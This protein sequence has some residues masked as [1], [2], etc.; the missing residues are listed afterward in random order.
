[1]FEQTT[2]GTLFEQQS[3]PGGDPAVAV[4]DARSIIVMANDAFCILLNRMQHHVLGQPLGGFTDTWFGRALGQLP[5]LSALDV[6]A[7]VVSFIVGP[8][9]GPRLVLSSSRGHGSSRGGGYILV[10]TPLAP[11]L[12]PEQLRTYAAT[13]ERS[14]LEGQQEMDRSREAANGLRNLLFMSISNYTLAEM[15]DYVYEQAQRLLNAVGMMVLW[16]SEHA[17]AWRAPENVEVLYATGSITDAA[18]LLQSPLTS[19]LNAEHKLIFFPMPLRDGQEEV[20]VR[21]A[22]PLLIEN[23][24]RGA[25]VLDLKAPHLSP[26]A[27]QVAEWLADQVIVAQGADRLQQKAQKAAALQERERLAREMHDAVMQSIYS[28]SLFA[29][30]GKRFAS[31]GQI[32][33]VQEYLQ[34]LSETAKQ[35]LKE[36][37]LL[38]YELQPAVLEQVGLVEAL[39]QRLDAVERRNGIT[40]RLEVEGSATF[41][42]SIEDGLYRICQEALNNALKHSSASEVTVRLSVKA[43]ELQLEI[44]DN[45]VGFAV[46]DPKFV[47]GEGLT[48]MR[49]RAQQLN[50]SLIVE[51]APQQGACVRIVLPLTDEVNPS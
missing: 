43:K 28:L 42:T 47:Y 48:T 24:I 27:H 49:E 46:N 44:R 25:L 11:T 2:G 31:S 36:L 23:Q 32:D 39:R 26:N 10:A 41:P 45:G 7:P 14:L 5:P 22:V 6:A 38:L 40:T 29:E 16:L 12:P 8:E 33:R 1:M 21:L 13:L 18:A 9:Q 51:S 30:A 19:L 20:S 15:L 3:S 37:R 50:A 35:A 17:Q 34:Q 4:V